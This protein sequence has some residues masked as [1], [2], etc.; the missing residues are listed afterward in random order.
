MR[1]RSGQTDGRANLTERSA[2]RRA[3]SSERTPQKCVRSQARARSSCRAQS[4]GVNV[5]SAKSPAKVFRISTLVE[6][7]GASSGSEVMFGVL[8][9]VLRPDCIADLGFS[10]RERQVSL[11]VPLGILR[12]F[13]FRTACIRCPLARASSKWG[14]PSGLVRNHDCLSAKCDGTEFYSLA[15]IGLRAPRAN[16]P[17]VGRASARDRVVRDGARLGLFSPKA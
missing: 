10:P 4:S 5:P 3:M 9:I 11:I 13:R 16:L 1:T 15:A 6:L 7:F 12:V 17:V 14:C 2:S 8:I